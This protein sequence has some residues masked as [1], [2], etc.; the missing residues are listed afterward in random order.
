MRSVWPLEFL[1]FL[2]LLLP[3]MIIGGLT[4]GIAYGAMAGLAFYLAWH[5][6]QLYRLERWFR[7]DRKRNPPEGS[8]VWGE[9]FD[10]YYRLQQRHLSRKRRLARVLREFR[11]STEAMPDGTVVLDHAGHIVW[12]NQAAQQLIGLKG[13]QDLGQP[14]GNLL[15]DPAFLKKLRDGHDDEPVEIESPLVP[16]RWLALSLIPYGEGQRLLLV[17]DMTRLNRLERMRRDFVANASHELRSPLT[18][19]QGYLDAMAEDEVV[20]TDWSMPVRKMQE[21]TRRMT[22]IVNDLLE[23]ARLESQE[24]DAPRDIVDVHGLAAR[25]REE[26]LALAVGPKEVRLEV[27]G[28]TRVLGAEKELYSAFSNLV[29]NAMRFTPEA[30]EVRIVWDNS[31][32][33]TGRFTV[34]DTGP[35]IEPRHIP[36]LTQRFYRVDSGRARKSGGTGL[37]LAIVKHVLQ[38]HGGRLE[39]DSTPG[40]GS[41]FRC[42]IPA[43]RVVRGD[44]TRIVGNI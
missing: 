41:R 17:R 8:G 27:S 40:K 20:A 15:R 34:T 43:D 31:P 14:I 6:R 18:V 7:L 3:A 24:P 35:G 42:V 19:L 21:Q 4:I 23:L 10:H 13:N 26:A 29:F 12:F 22:D 32:A 16:D 36:R 1:R 44:G 25:I 11:N 30:G 28:D 9:V 2:L 38:R 33:G 39:I 5:L 37:G